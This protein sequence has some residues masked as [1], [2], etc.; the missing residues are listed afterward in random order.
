MS[1]RGT[2]RARVWRGKICD[3]FLKPFWLVGEM[4]RSKPYTLHYDFFNGEFHFFN[5]VIWGKKVFFFSS[6]KRVIRKKTG[7]FFEKK[8]FNAENTI[9]AIFSKHV[10]N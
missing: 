4:Q 8:I 2:N 5:F 9:H 7:T 10:L 6:V 3:L 1:K